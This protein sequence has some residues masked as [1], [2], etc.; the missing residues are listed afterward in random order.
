MTE[1][2]AWL[3]KQ[4]EEEKAERQRQQESQYEQ[5]RLPLYEEPVAVQPEHPEEPRSRVV[6]L[7]L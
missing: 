2:P 3:I 5:L 4:L 7:E 1:L 6:I